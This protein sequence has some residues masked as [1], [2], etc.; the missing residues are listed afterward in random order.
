MTEVGFKTRVSD[1]TPE[2]RP[3]SPP[4]KVVEIERIKGRETV[5]ISDN[6]DTF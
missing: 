1:S 5:L 2:Y 3:L 4:D 6:I